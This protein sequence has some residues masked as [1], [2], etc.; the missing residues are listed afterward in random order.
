MESLIS[1]I[2]ANSVDKE[3]AIEEISNNI[4]EACSK[5][6]LY[7]LSVET[8]S[9][10]FRHSKQL[11][12][13]TTHTIISKTAAKHGKKSINILSSL[14]VDEEMSELEL[15]TLLSLIPG[16]RIFSLLGSFTKKIEI[17]YEETLQNEKNARKSLEE[18]IK[19]KKKELELYENEI[20][21]IKLQ[22]ELTKL[23]EIEGFRIK[24]E[25]NLGIFEKMDK[26]NRENNAF[27]DKL[28]SE[29]K[30]KSD[31]FEESIIKAK[32][33]VVELQQI[34]KESSIIIKTCEKKQ[35][36]FPSLEKKFTE[37]DAKY[38]KFFMENNI[39]L[40]GDL[41]CGKTCLR[42]A[43]NDEEFVPLQPGQLGFQHGGI[44]NSYDKMINIFEYSGYFQ[45]KRFIDTH[46][47][48]TSFYMVLL[49]FSKNKREGFDHLF[50]FWTTPEFLNGRE[51]ILVKTKIDLEDEKDKDVTTGEAIK[52]AS[53]RGYG[54]FEVSAKTWQG[55]AE[56][57]E[58]ILEIT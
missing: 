22:R 13:T 37:I 3:N 54:Y 33:Y 12:Y 17:D 9:D 48:L 47:S 50:N 15:E 52:F 4:E 43:L 40:I 16:V 7:E 46:A 41:C 49:C 28:E 56:L 30:V 6:E 51:I 18:E 10:V 39:L 8:L 29:I 55:I 20:T 23:Q 32:N 44:Y 2:K 38:Q 42:D 19:T 34:A 26:K 1:I 31:D 5:D 45:N 25:H 14:H 24:I 58:Y 35:K 36:L 11:N 21:E 53:E 27:R 57:R